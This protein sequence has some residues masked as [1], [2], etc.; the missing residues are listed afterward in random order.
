MSTDQQQYSLDNQ[1][2]AIRQYAEGNNMRIVRT[3]SDS[4]KTG[5]TLASC[6]AL[7]KLLEDV[8]NGQADFSAVLVYDVSRW[9]RFQDA[10]ESAYYE[11]RCR[12]AQIAVHY[13]AEAFPND[14][15]IMA[16]LIKALKRAMAAEYSRE[17]SV[18]VFAGQ[19]RLT[20]LGFRQGGM[21]G[22]GFRR[23]LVDQCGS[24]KLI[25]GLVRRRA[26]QPIGLS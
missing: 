20:E 10:D 16:V 6:P 13:C 22:Y 25:L 26:S 17:L 15:S 18:K 14:G 19:A 23:L 11:Y 7:R 2:N 3:H 21:A 9:G 1:S 8:E 12:R 24:P 5:L 4:G